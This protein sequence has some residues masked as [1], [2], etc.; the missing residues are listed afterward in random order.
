MHTISYHLA[1][2]HM[3]DLRHHAQ[4][5]ALARAARRPGWRRRPGLRPRALRRPPAV[6]GAAQAS[7][8]AAA[9]HAPAP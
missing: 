3:A 1:Q 5:D 7:Q 6:P 8:P 4:R 9:A 2:A